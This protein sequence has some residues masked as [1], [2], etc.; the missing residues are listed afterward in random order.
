MPEG[1][2]YKVTLTRLGGGDPLAHN[3]HVAQPLSISTG[4]SN[5]SDTCRR[6]R[7]TPIVLW[8]CV[9]A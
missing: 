2:L 5:T 9:R 6:T 3:F 1:L 7:P 8:S 4:V